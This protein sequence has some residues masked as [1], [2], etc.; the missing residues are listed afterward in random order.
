M[1]N[2]FKISG[3][4]FAI[5]FIWAAYLQYNDPDAF[6]WYIIYGLAAFGCLLFAYGRLGF[7]VSLIFCLAYLIATAFLWPEKFE[8]F[9]I[10][11]GDIV[12]IE[13]GREACGMLIVAL[14]F[15]VFALRL[16]YI[17]GRP[18]NKIV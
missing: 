3:V 13:K 16:R 14:V 12:N 9:T 6:L 1:K 8:G 2:I 7:K 4:V 18:E 11:E 17:K 15:L 5:L 10:G